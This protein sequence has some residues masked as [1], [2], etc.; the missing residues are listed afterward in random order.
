MAAYTH[1]N[2]GTVDRHEHQMESAEA[3]FMEAQNLWGKGDQL[4]T[5]PFNA[6]CMY[7]LGCVSLDQGKL[8][9]AV[10]HLKDAML[11]TEMRKHNMVAEHARTIFK[12][13]E[14]LE[15]EPREVAEAS[16]LRQEAERLLRLREPT[17]K[18]P[19]KEGTYDSM[20]NIL[21]R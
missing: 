4:R 10:K 18:E 2:L 1:F 5:D 11:I 15:Q 14:A 19:G 21:W 3:H 17:A 7:R 12:L 13:S 20:V 8:E 6:A 9:A 16:R